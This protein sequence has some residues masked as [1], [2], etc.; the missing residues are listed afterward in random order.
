MSCRFLPVQ[1]FV[2]AAVLSIAMLLFA[3]THRENA[4]GPQ[5]K[6]VIDLSTS[7][8]ANSETMAPQ[9]TLVSP[10]ELGG[11]W[12][13][14]TLPSTR[15]IAPLA[16]IEAGHKNFPDSESLIT[17]D[18]VATYERLHGAVPQGAM[19][20]LASVKPGTDPV[21]NH[22]ALHFLVEARNV[23]AIGGAGT[24]FV[25]SDEN[26]Y[27]A[28]KGIY[29]LENISNLAVVPRSNVVGVAAPEK[30]A[31]ASQGPVRLMALVK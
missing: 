11:A 9:T 15:L 2:V 7:I 25:S 22:D 3:A 14:E 31:G 16:V 30:I 4:A 13:L 27:L 18:D 10:A 1:I 20:L 19:I 21:L 12:N 24:Q 29:E 17:M 23:V 28:R 26:S 8:P 6:T 5:Y